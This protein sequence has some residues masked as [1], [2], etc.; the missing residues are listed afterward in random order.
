MRLSGRFRAL[1]RGKRQVEILR[2]RF[3]GSDGAQPDANLILD[4]KRN[5]SGT[6][7]LYGLGRLSAGLLRL[8]AVYALPLP[9]PA[10][11]SCGWRITI[12]LSSRK[13]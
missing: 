13:D 6:A 2:P 1:C 11:R 8:P 5:L 9:K 4:G 12:N 7:T 10:T 3:L